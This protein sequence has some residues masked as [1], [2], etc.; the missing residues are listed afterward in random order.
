MLSGMLGVRAAGVA[1]QK[2]GGAGV[3]ARP[4]M[5]GGSDL[6]KMDDG[7]ATL[8]SHRFT[9]IANRVIFFPLDPR[10]ASLST[11]KGGPFGQP[12]HR[13]RDY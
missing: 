3:G 10:R 5:G 7:G 9:D 6:V 11:V 13:F 1:A 12:S 4:T 2:D 8:S